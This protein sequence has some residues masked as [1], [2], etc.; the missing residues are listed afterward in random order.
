MSLETLIAK[1]SSVSHVTWKK[2]IGIVSSQG[3]QICNYLWRVD[4]RIGAFRK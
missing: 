2:L 4:L 1:N 3:S